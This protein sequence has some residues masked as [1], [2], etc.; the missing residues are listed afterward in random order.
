ML[1]YYHKALL[2]QVASIVL[3]PM[4]LLVLI[5]TCDFTTIQTHEGGWL[6]FVRR[7]SAALIVLWFFD[8]MLLVLTLAMKEL[9]LGHF[10]YAINEEQ[11]PVEEQVLQQFPTLGES[12]T[13]SESL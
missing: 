10:C 6:M 8:I 2:T 1:N 11:D 4:I 7:A 5:A 13:K 12:T 3:L 9:V